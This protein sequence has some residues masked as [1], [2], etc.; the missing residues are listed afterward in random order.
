MKLICLDM[1]GCANRGNDNCSPDRHI[2]NDKFSHVIRSGKN[3]CEMTYVDP[4]LAKRLS[5]TILQYDLYIVATTS[6]RL[7][8]RQE[9]FKELLTLR[10][11][12]GERLVGYTPNL[13]KESAF[14]GGGPPRSEE[15]QVFLKNF[16]EPVEK[17]VIIDDLEEARLKGPNIQFFKCDPE[18]GY[19]EEIDQEVRAWLDQ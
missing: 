12:P 6:W 15:I 16:K 17:C 4:E 8:Y 18:L 19:T 1:D 9:E 14:F 11:L 10:G 2:Y 5:A 13:Y 3:T 7:F